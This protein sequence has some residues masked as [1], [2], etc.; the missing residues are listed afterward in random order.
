M[1][2]SIPRPKSKFLKVLCTKCNNEQTIF[3]KSSSVVKCLVC[4]A[5]L[6]N[7]TGGKAKVK[8]KVIQVME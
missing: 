5:E 6:A 4:G 3:N 2:E 1:K 8:T 7:P